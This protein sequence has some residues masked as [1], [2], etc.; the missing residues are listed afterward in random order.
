MVEKIDHI[1]IAVTSIEEQLPWYRD[2]LGLPFLGIEEVESQKVRVAMFAAGDIR[3]ELLEPTSPE[4][5]IARFIEKKGAGMHHL[6]YRVNDI[7]QTMERLRE[8]S[9]QMIDSAPRPGA[10]GTKIA[11][12]HPKS[13]H[14][15][16]TE[17][18]EGGG[19]KS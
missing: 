6:S 5:A 18:C 2:I 3:I 16:L 9:V 8:N 17:L 1:G 4:S 15:V 12:L 14:G 19:A 10:H 7:A 11:F 13:T